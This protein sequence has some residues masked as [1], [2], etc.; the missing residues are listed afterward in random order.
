MV[1]TYVYLAML[2]PEEHAGFAWTPGHINTEIVVMCLQSRCCS[3]RE[4]VSRSSASS[5]SV[6]VLTLCAPQD[7]IFC[8]LLQNYNPEFALNI[9][10]FY[11]FG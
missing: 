10:S 3:R 7:W 2:L 9:P 6:E 8:D 5:N 4:T 1:L 11:I